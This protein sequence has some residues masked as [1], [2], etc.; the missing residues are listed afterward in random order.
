MDDILPEH[1]AGP[2]KLR[3]FINLILAVVLIIFLGSVLAITNDITWV[4]N[5]GVF[6]ADNMLILFELAGFIAIGILVLKMAK[7]LDGTKF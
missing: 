1:T 5:L 6:L 4:R 7:E 3:V 2:G